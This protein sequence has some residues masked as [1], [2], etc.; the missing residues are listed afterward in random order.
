MQRGPA[1]GT[2]TTSRHSRL[3]QRHTLHALR[4]WARCPNTSRCPESSAGTE[5]APAQ[6]EARD[7]IR[8][9]EPANPWTSPG[10]FGHLPANRLFLSSRLTGRQRSRRQTVTT[11]NAS[12]TRATSPRAGREVQVPH[13]RLT[14]SV[15]PTLLPRADVGLGDHRFPGRVA[16]IAEA[17]R[18][19]AG[20]RRATLER[21]RSAEPSRDPSAP[22]TNTRSSSAMP[23]SAR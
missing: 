10:I 14:V 15:T 16:Q 7:R 11:A 21:R 22:A 8:T 18:P 17:Q 3:R 5:D 20:G 13:R 4:C 23:L 6:T 9:R 19:Q 12:R 2:P 1:P